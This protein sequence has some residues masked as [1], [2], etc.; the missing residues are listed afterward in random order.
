MILA[1]GKAT[2]NT[3]G[4]LVWRHIHPVISLILSNMALNL[5]HAFWISQPSDPGLR[6][7]SGLPGNVEERETDTQTERVASGLY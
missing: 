2:A 7:A 3:T 6:S 5:A 1:N 4:Q